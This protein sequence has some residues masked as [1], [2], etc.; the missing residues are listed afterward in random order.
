MKAK[1]PHRTGVQHNLE[2]KI[3]RFTRLQK[4][5]RSARMLQNA[6]LSFLE[7][8]EQKSLRDFLHYDIPDLLAE[9]HVSLDCHDP[10]TRMDL[11]RINGVLISLDSALKAGNTV[12]LSP[13]MRAILIVLEQYD[14][15]PP[16]FKAKQK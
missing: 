13:W 14:L 5:A 6:E 16:P 3:A 12:E 7:Q 15:S 1:L 2:S 11:R 9:A 8:Q 4:I 10:L